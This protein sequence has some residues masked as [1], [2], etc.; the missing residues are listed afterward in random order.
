MKP[1]NK[2]ITLLLVLL[3]LT[4]CEETPEKTSSYNFKQ[5]YGNLVVSTLE[6]NPPDIIY[7]N[8]DFIIKVKLENQGAYDLTNGKIKIFGFDEKYISLEENEKGIISLE[9]EKD[10]L[11]GRS[12]FNPSGALA[13]IEFKA[14]AHDLYPG[15]ESEKYHYQ[16][17]A[18]YDY[19]TEL[20]QTICINPKFYETYDSGCKVEPKLFFQGQGSPLAITSLE[21]II[22]PGSIPQTEFRV[23]LENKGEGKVKQA[24]LEQA[25][26]GP[27]PLDCEFQN[28]PN[29]NKRNFDF[30]EE[31]EATLICKKTLEDQRSYPTTLFLDLS[32]TYSLKE[33]REITLKR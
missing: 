8:S 2:F 9:E 29:P 12:A 32:F 17:K 13:H 14:K 22:R 7:P 27:Q 15:A 26:L 21:E 4:A 6:N 3:F 18:E 31:Q 1:I 16:I 28:N 25:K 20:S 23:I 24:R 10:F 11:P 19:K 30:D 5:G 33:N